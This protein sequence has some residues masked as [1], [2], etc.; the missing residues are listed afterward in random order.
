MLDMIDA[1]IYVLVVIVS[2]RYIRF[3]INDRMA[4]APIHLCDYTTR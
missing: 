4:V 2:N 3:E 1:F